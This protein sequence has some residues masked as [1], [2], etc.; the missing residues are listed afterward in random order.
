MSNRILALY[1]E[2][3]EPGDDTR[4]WL[5]ISRSASGQPG[6]FFT[7]TWMGSDEGGELTVA[8]EDGNALLAPVIE[9]LNKA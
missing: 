1:E 2:V 9:W 3:P 6:L 8:V 4:Y 5:E 7:V